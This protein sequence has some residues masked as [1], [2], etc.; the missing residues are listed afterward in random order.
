MLHILIWLQYFGVFISILFLSLC[1]YIKARLLGNKKRAVPLFNRDCQIA[2]VGGGIGGVSTAYALLHSGYKN[3]TIYEAR[4]KLGGNA[5][6]HIWQN[7]KSN[8][9]TGLSVLAWPVIFRNY[10]HLL[11]ELNIPTTTVEL[12]FFIH[13]KQDNSFFAHRKQHI[14]TQQYNTNLKRWSRMVNT[15]RWVTEYFNG[16][17][18]SLYHFTFLNPFNYI[19]MRCLS[20][21]FGVSNRF[22]NHIV[23]PMYAS[24]FLSTKLSFIP[25]SILPTIDSLIS[26]QPNQIPTMQTWLQTSIDVFDKMTQGATIKTNHPVTKVHIQRKDSNHIMITINEEKTIYDRIVFACN[27][28]ATVNALTNGH[29]KI[30]SLLKLMLSNVTYGDDDDL[31]LLDGI[32]HRDINVLPAEYAKELCCDYANYIDLKYDSRNQCYY[33]YNTFILSSWLPN[34]H[35]MMKE[36]QIE[37]KTM[38]PM[39]VTYAPYNQ[40]GPKIDEKK[41]FGKVDNRRAHPSLSFRNQTI[42]LLMRIVQGENGMYFCG[43]AVTPANGH[44][45]SLI[46]GFAV[47]ELIGAKYPFSENISALRDY[48]R[49][50]RMCVN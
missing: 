50:K 48:N 11:N 3:I 45:L 14:H 31:N 39:L 34:V 24:S 29:T 33:H 30:S 23:V 1:A 26:L 10:I 46:S 49:F 8:I 7:D 28:D 42:A 12:P 38:E 43:N 35:A 2:I 20:F 4:D 5:K 37:H 32:I 18:A 22:W 17:E 41:I 16:K 19:S 47:A 25:S 13:N 6:T 36:N 9:T 15:V 40:P 27:A 44:D 21:C